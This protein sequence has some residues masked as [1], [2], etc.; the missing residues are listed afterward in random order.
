M[1][2][3]K[4]KVYIKLLFWIFFVIFNQKTDGI[5]KPKIRIL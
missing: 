3:S 2:L 5:F 4:A 1:I